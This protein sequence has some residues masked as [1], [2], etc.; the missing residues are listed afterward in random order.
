MKQSSV[1]SFFKKDAAA[2]SL[3]TTKPV[4][5]V[6]EAT[7]APTA[8]LSMPSS[9]KK[10]L[11]EQDAVSYS[12][13]QRLDYEMNK[14]QRVYKKSW[15][16]DNPWLVYN[17]EK[18][19]M[20][21]R[22]CYEFRDLVLEINPS[23]NM[24]MVDGC[25]LFRKPVVDRHGSRKSHGICMS[26]KASKETPAETPLGKIQRRLISQDQER[27]RVLFNSAHCTAKQDWSINS[28]KSLIELQAKNGLHVGENYWTNRHGPKMFMKHIAEVQR[29]DTKQF[30]QECRFFSVMAD[31]STDRSIADQEAVYVRYIKDG[32]PVN[33]FIGLQELES[34]DAE[35]VL[36]A[37]DQVLQDNA[38]ISLD[39]QRQKMVNVNLD[40]ASVNMGIYSG[41]AVRLQQRNGGHVTVT[42]CINHC[43]EL[44][45]LDMR[46]EEP[47][48]KEFESTVKGIFSYY[49]YS[50]KRVRAL[51]QEAAL[52]DVALEHFG[53]I[54]AIRWISS[55]HRAL[56]S[57]RKNYTPTCSHLQNIVENVPR[58]AAK[59]SGLLRKLRSAKFITFLHFMLD[60]TSHI[61][62]L[63]LVFQANDLMLIDVL[64]IIETALLRLIEMKNRPGDCVSSIVHGFAYEGVM[65]SRPVEPELQKLHLSMIDSAV[66]QI[67]SRFMA[68]QQSPLT[69]FSV[70]DYRQWP[71]DKIELASYGTKNVEH[72]VQHFAS[73]LTEVEVRNIPKEFASFKIYAS[74]LRTSQPDMVFRDLLL[75][76]PQSFQNFLSLIK[77]MMTVSMSTAVVERGFSHMN[78]V[79]SST[80]T[81]LGNDVLNNLLEIKLNGPSI[82]DFDPE[83]AII[84][85]LDDGQRKR[86]IGG[87]KTKE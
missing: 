21:C 52:L 48:V 11:P 72:L 61:V 9:N 47:Y 29:M 59:A 67:D 82:K 40:G 3:P 49:H 63:S 74:K 13:E 57:L 25:N 73:V 23:A 37:V 38:G 36:K 86:H 45:I 34:G 18:D 43:L 51:E 35:G 62:P 19:I 46:N 83:P 14:R 75:M 66:E 64:P 16:N 6:I 50:P 41:L 76:P 44:A 15:E 85:W 78:L 69:D 42:H 30:L 26:R 39:M 24:A 17:E 60:L 10:R 53:G 71:H 1:L 32:R 22:V 4:V 33:R 65:L 8:T 54:Q 5:S 87:H 80:R 58:D 27:F 56:E 68:L 81:L 12:R 55:Q 70:L 7:N 31:G 79:K 28:F 2:A 20:W 84:H 77:I